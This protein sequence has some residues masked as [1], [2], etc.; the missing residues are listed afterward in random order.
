P[1]IDTDFDDIGRQKVIDYVVDKYGKSQV[2]Q[3]IT[4]GSMAAKSSIKDVARVMDLPLAEANALTALL[5]KNIPGKD[6]S[7]TTLRDF[8]DYVP[9]LKKRLGGNDLT[10]RCLNLAADLEGSIRNTGIHA[11]GV[12]IAPGDL[13]DY[14][15]VSTVKDSD[16][17][18]TQFDGSVIEQ[19]G[20]L[21]M[22]FLGLKTLSIIRDA[23]DL[24]KEGHDVDI[25]LQKLPLDDPK[26]WHLYQ[27]GDTVGTFQFESDGMRKYLRELKPTD[28][29]DLIAMNALYRPGPMDYIPSF[30]NRKHGVENVEYPHEK[31]E[32][33][34]KPTYGIMV[35]QEQIMQCAQIIGGYTLGGA[36]L[37]R[38]AMGKKDKDKM[39]KE[40]VKF[41]KGAKELHS[42]PEA[43]AN[44]IFD[45]M[46]KF[47]G[48]GFN[49]SH[50][51]AYSIL[52][53]QT[54]YLK[55]NYP[56]EY[57]AAVL[58]HNSNNTEDLGFFLDECKRM[59][60]TVLGPCVNESKLNFSV[61]E[62]GE[63][64]FGLGAI[65]GLG[66]N[67][68]IGIMNERAANG[69]YKSIFDL[70]RRVTARSIN[71]KNLEALVYAGA[72]DCIEG[73][74]RAQYLAPLPGENINAI[75]KALKLA[76][77]GNAAAPMMASLFGATE[78][79]SNGEDIKLPKVEQMSLLEKLHHEKDTT[80]IYFSG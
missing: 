7:K 33:I 43:K 69:P 38:R 48:Y 56:A 39:A 77:G 17:Y 61:N 31:L 37:L 2:A 18:V 25:D 52:A 64:R 68:V 6:I 26:T 74:H 11:A 41:V 55:A 44:E 59:G 34:L 47:A 13:T 3:I 30:C 67:A 28:I 32:P 9:E 5:P 10:A 12:I 63:I 23:G 50:A 66:E 29:E 27:H 71:R 45:T 72:F 60:L 36:D 65:K 19:A 1:D 80:G 58:T 22:D 16:L 49:R 70:P 75:E 20:M 24:I 51:A 73:S 8:Y 42:I 46:E 15:P 4:F 78:V 76:S 40:R 53:F 14:I 21:K 35:Y 79:R 54:A 57:M 62:K